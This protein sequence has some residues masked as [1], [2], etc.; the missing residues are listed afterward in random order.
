MSIEKVTVRLP[1]NDVL[2]A[3]WYSDGVEGKCR[4]E[5]VRFEVIGEVVE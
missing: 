4:F 5:W 1:R 3:L 2:S